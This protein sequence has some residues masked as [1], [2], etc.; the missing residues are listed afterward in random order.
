MMETLAWLAY[1][2]IGAFPRSWSFCGFCPRT[3]IAMPDI[4]RQ[5]CLR[6]NSNGGGI[7]PDRGD[8]MA[9]FEFQ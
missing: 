2:S 7:I 9:K 5:R 8:D 1:V 3:S 4:L 6:Q